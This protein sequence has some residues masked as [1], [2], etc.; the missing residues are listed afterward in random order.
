MTLVHFSRHGICHNN[1]EMKVAVCKWSVMQDPDWYC[2]GMFKVMQRWDKSIDVLGNVFWRILAWH[3]NEAALMLLWLLI[4]IYETRHLTF[5]TVAPYLM[6]CGH[7]LLNRSTLPIK[8]R[9]LTYWTA[10]AYLLNCGSLLT[11]L[12]L[13]YIWNLSWRCLRI[14][15]Q[16]R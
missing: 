3:W 16:I 11:E 2:K 7:Y 9:Q 1:E 6:N 10:A 15:G 8:L 4:A 5:C 13:R 12:C 14:N